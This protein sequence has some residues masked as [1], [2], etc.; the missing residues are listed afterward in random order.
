MPKTEEPGLGAEEFV[1]LFLLMVSHCAT[2]ALLERR[3]TPAGARV[4]LCSNLL[5]RY[6]IRPAAGVLNAPRHFALRS[7]NLR[8][9]RFSRFPNSCNRDRETAV[10]IRD[11]RA[12]LEFSQVGSE[13]QA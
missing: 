6:R 5:G 9:D 3:A 11:V 8:P 13:C 4:P 7:T 10:G 2:A 12:T 1:S